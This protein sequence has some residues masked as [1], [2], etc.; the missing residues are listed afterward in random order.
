MKATTRGL[1]LMAPAK[2]NLFLHILGCRPD[3]YHELQTVFQLLDY[4]DTLTF[5]NRS[6]QHI[7]IEPE[8]KGVRYQDNLIFKAAA[9]LQAHTSSDRGVNIMLDKR[10]PMGG[11]LGGG[12]SNAA[13]TLL[14]LNQLWEVDLPVEELCSIGL[15]IG[16]DVPVFIQG[17]SAWA[18]G[19]GENLSPI[20]LPE[21]WFL[22]VKPGCHVS[23]ADIFSCEELTRGTPAITVATFFEQG[24]QND[25]EFTVSR[26]YPEVKKALTWLN[27]YSAAKLTGTGAC[28]FTS[29]DTEAR[30]KAVSQEVPSQWECFVAKGINYSPCKV[31]VSKYRHQNKIS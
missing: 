2:V 9:A 1:T 26:R 30:A 19:I 3:G 12:S 15:N 4:G 20:N 21:R 7:C 28:I 24:G 6:D 8:I 17:R 11:G 23:T 29:F 27:R 5:G 25:C 13:T 10:L 18:D 16:A 22:I 14:A 31:E